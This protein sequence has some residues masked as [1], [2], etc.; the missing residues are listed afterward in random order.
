MSLFA[1]LRGSSLTLPAF[2]GRSVDRNDVQCISV[3][4][5]PFHV[6]MGANILLIDVI[7][8]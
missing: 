7:N 5:S 4:P 3:I 6:L 8:F 1:V 2:V